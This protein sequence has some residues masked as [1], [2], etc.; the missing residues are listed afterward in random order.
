MRIL[1]GGRGSGVMSRVLLVA[2]AP[3]AALGDR[4]VAGPGRIP[5]RVTTARRRRGHPVGAAGIGG[6]DVLVGNAVSWRG[7]TVARERAS[8][9][10][11]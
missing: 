10:R 6:G 1:G 5:A 4:G 11:S 7:R 2:T 3:A 9:G 8:P